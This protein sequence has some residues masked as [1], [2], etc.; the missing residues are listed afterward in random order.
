M[1]RVYSGVSMPMIV[2]PKKAKN[3][4]PIKI[5]LL[6]FLMIFIRVSL[7]RDKVVEFTNAKVVEKIALKRM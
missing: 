2:L 4:N 3:I 5:S 1:K 7:Y 6:G